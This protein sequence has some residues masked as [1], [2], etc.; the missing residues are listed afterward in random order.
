MNFICRISA[1]FRAGALLAFALS[2]SFLLPSAALAQD[3]LDRSALADVPFPEPSW[4]WSEDP[5]RVKYEAVQSAAA[6]AER[7]CGATEFHAWQ[8]DQKQP[9]NAA[10]R[11]AGWLLEDFSEGMIEQQIFRAA[12]GGDEIVMTWIPVESGMALF[13]CEAFPVGAAPVQAAAAPPAEEPT[14]PTDT[15]SADEDGLNL[16]DAPWLFA[17]LFGGIGSF[18]LGAAVR[19]RRR[20]TAS[21][22]W[23]TTTATVLSS[24]VVERVEKDSEGDDTTWYVPTVRYRYEV[25][26]RTY[27]G[28]RLRF[29]DIKQHSEKAA[30]GMIA[31]YRAGAAISVRY[32]PAKPSESTIE[33]K[34]PGLGAPIFVGGILLVF[35]VLAA[36]VGLGQTA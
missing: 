20:A 21:L 35:A 30:A 34:K 27:E 33:T 13:L 26:G 23:P 4:A 16:A 9:V 24:E 36:L 32:D 1:A 25:G 31:P 12:K 5:N 14:A 17:A 19:N 2:W 15:P 18:T 7:S 22:S 11:A 29:G 28:A 10:F 6:V 3:R 8:T